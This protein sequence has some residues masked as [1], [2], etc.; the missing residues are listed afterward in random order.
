MIAVAKFILEIKAPFAAVFASW[1]QS[2]I[3]AHRQE[4]K[5]HEASMH[6]V[7][8]SPAFIRWQIRS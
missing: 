2:S 6:N 4:T 3:E 7:P 5:D 8:V 1:R